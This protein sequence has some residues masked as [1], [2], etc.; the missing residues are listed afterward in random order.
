MGMIIGFVT[1]GISRPTIVGGLLIVGLADNQ[2]DLLSIYIYQ[3]TEKFEERAAF[4]ATLGNFATRFIVAVSFVAMALSFLDRTL[5]L[6]ALGWG[7]I[8][9]AGLTWLVAK[10]SRGEWL[11]EIVKHLG[12]AAVVIAASL[13]IGHLL[14]LVFTMGGGKVAAR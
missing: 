7:V 11:S 2:T 14:T 12:V 3:E 10:K 13:G 6:T 5:V 8:L 4:R 1:A 9:L